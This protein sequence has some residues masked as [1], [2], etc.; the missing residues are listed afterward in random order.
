MSTPI[1][2]VADLDVQFTTPDGP[3]HAVRKLSF[4]V[5]AGETLGIDGESGSGKSQ[6]VIAVMN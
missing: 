1:L 5:S 2:Q 4:D 3:V 6:T